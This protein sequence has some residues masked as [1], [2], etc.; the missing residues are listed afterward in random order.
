M[1]LCLSLVESFL[2]ISFAVNHHN[3]GSAYVKGEIRSS[4]LVVSRIVPTLCTCGAAQ[5]DTGPVLTDLISDVCVA[6]LASNIQRAFSPS[7]AHEYVMLPLILTI[8]RSYYAH[9][10]LL[11]IID[12]VAGET[13]SVCRCLFIS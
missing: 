5:M 13:L 11:R 1:T 12:C 6:A 2:L 4:I 9:S 8:K 3:L 7:L 10:S